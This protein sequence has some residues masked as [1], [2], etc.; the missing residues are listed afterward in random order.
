M[1]RKQMAQNITDAVPHLGALAA[2][3]GWLPPI[4]AAFSIL[5]ICLQIAEKVTGRKIHVMLAPIC[6]RV[7]R[8]CS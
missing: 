7:K 8:W 5:W 4:A 6:E 2:L 3:A 1:D